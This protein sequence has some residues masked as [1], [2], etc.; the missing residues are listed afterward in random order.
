MEANARTSGPPQPGKPKRHLRN[1]LLDTR[2]QLRWVLKVVLAVSIIVAVMGY[3]LYRTVG[4]AT[5]QILLQKLGDPVLT[6]EAQNAFIKQAEN[7]KRVTLIKLVAGLASLVVLL[8]IMTIVSTHRIA[9]PVYKMRKL[10]NSID[11]RNLQL[12]E[13][14][15]KSDELQEAF[16]DFD[17]M[18]RRIREHRREDT[19]ELESVKDLVARGGADDE[20]LERIDAMIASYRDSVKMN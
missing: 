1:F 14:L 19:G 16:V 10:Y 2:F 8:G 5:D 6:V 18:L 12:F 11:G 15:R 4:E 9:G 7:D 13:K 3:F 17:N 20:V